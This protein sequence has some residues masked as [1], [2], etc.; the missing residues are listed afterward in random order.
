M[1]EEQDSRAAV[2]Q[3]D[4]LV[5]GHPLAARPAG[6]TRLGR[7]RL[8]GS[9]AFERLWIAQVV[10]ATWDLLGLVAIT[11]LADRIGGN[12]AGASI[13]LVLAARI[14]PGLFLAPLAGVLIDRWD[15]KRV[16]VV[17]DIG[18]AMVM[19]ALPFV[20]SVA[21][22]VVASLILEVFTLLWSPAKEAS[23]PHL[24]PR[25]HLTTAN[26]L[27]LVAAYGTFPLG[28]ALFT[29]FAKLAGWSAGFTI[30]RSLH[31]DR[32]GLAFYFDALTFLV[33]AFIVWSLP[34]PR[35]E[36]HLAAD[37]TS[38]RFDAASTLHEL[39]EG[40]R[41]IFVNPIVRAVIF[42]LATGL[43]GGGMLIPLGSLFA[44]DVLGAGDAGYGSLITSLGVGVAL[45]VGLVSIVQRRLPKQW[46]FTFA[47][48][49][50]GV[51]LVFAASASTL[52][53]AVLAV[54]VIGLCAGAV[55]VLGFTLL[56]ENVDDELRGRVFTA[57][58]TLVRLCLILA[59]TIGPLLTGLFDHLSNRFWQRDVTLLGLDVALPGVRLTLWLAGLIIVAAG[60][61][62]AVSLRA[63]E[64]ARVAPASFDL[65]GLDA[66]SVDQVVTV[67]ER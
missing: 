36:R 4:L 32:A 62:A 20:N 29:L 52:T 19:V 16:M 66:D 47:V 5:S 14:V 45:G 13:G 39:R 61:F 15:R 7:R 28:A 46:V 58:Y 27:S 23:V 33:A 12:Y 54:G 30:L 44:A 60:W 59:M 17:C 57:L 41:F 50:A 25:D 63:G 1:A 65:D 26:S 64:R 10:S 31:A 9:S 51:S 22:L 55:Y 48:L 56:H 35:R 24:V 11:A 37:R 38:H 18:R 40:W 2:S 6:R 34:I 49:A 8:F 3:R 21:G 43:I 42:G 53:P 67:G